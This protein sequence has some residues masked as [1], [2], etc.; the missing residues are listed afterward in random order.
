MQLFTA[1]FTS[2]RLLTFIIETTILGENVD[3]LFT[4]LAFQRVCQLDNKHDNR[5][6]AF[7]FGNTDLTISNI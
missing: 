6:F 1:D 2:S 5:N 4:E 7:I 3:E